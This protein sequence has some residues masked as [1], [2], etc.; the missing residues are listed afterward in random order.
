MTATDTA[1]GAMSL[2]PE[3]LR[4]IGAFEGFALTERD[5]GPCEAAVNELVARGAVLSQGAFDALVSF[6]RNAGE[7]ALQGEIAAHAT[8]QDLAGVAALVLA[9][10]RSGGRPSAGL[11]QRRKA[12]AA[13]LLDATPPPIDRDAHLTPQEHAACWA[14]DAEP[15]EQARQRCVAHRKLIWHKAQQPAGVN[16]AADGNGWDHLFRRERWHALAARTLLPS[17]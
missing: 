15:S 16:D 12:E 4:R 17:R 2:S 1:A 7:E 9:Y 14:F 3:G 6:C 5:L 10:N 13:L 11:T 8:A